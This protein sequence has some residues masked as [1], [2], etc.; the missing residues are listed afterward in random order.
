MRTSRTETGTQLRTETGT[1]LV[2][3]APPRSF[4]LRPDRPPPPDRRRPGGRIRRGVANGDAACPHDPARSRWRTIAG[5]PVP[6]ADPREL[7]PIPPR[8][9]VSRPASL[10]APHRSL[11]GLR[12]LR[13]AEAESPRPDA[14]DAREPAVFPFD[15]TDGDDTDPAAAPESAGAPPPAGLA[16]PSPAASEPD[17]HPHPPVAPGPPAF[18][19]PIQQN[20]PSPPPVPARIPQ[21]EPSTGPV[22][23]RISQNEP[24]AAPIGGRIPQNEPSPAG[25]IAARAV[26]ALALVFLLAAAL[27]AALGAGAAGPAG[28][29]SP[30]GDVAPEMIPHHRETSVEAPV[31]WARPTDAGRLRPSMPTRVSGYAGTFEIPISLS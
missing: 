1:Q 16:G 30:G 8:D 13:R 3:Q 10:P 21:N 2:C 24:S 29:G 18:F 15:A 9:H 23:A 11:D 27:S 26:P 12:K 4:Q 6:V 17:R 19:D 14:G 20:E 28:A 5:R 31:G 7:P 25:R 22:P